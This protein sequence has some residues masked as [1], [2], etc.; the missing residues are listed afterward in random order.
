[1]PNGDKGG[2][3]AL[4]MLNAT[5]PNGSPVYSIKDQYDLLQSWGFGEDML[6]DSSGKKITFGENETDE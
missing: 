5:N 1:M 2:V 6:Y 4:A 3:T